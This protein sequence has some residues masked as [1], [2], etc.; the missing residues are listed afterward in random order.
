M[1]CTKVA[2]QLLFIVAPERCVNHEIA[3]KSS[4]ENL[5]VLFADFIFKLSNTYVVL[6]TDEEH[7]SV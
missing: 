5:N 7:I 6:I 2:E 1:V 3:F 4:K